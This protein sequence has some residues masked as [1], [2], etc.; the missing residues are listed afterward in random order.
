ME[1]G[2]LVA[3]LPRGGVDVAKLDGRP[4]ERSDLKAS[5]LLYYRM[6]APIRST[7]SSSRRHFELVSTCDICS[8]RSVTGEGG[9]LRSR[10]GNWAIGP[11][12][13]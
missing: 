10:L 5:R 3:R 9:T 6:P 12:R 11:R 7:H 13:W 2:Q 1:G 4:A 8:L